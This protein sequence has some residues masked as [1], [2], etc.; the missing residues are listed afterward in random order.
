MTCSSTHARDT[1]QLSP[2]AGGCGCHGE[3]P[4]CSI[5]LHLQVERTAWYRKAGMQEGALLLSFCY[6]YG[7]WFF[8]HGCFWNGSKVVSFP[9]GVWI[10]PLLLAS[11]LGTEETPESTHC[12][13]PLSIPFLGAPQEDCCLNSVGQ[14]LQDS[15]HPC[16]SPPSSTHSFWSPKTKV[17]N[18]WTVEGFHGATTSVGKQLLETSWLTSVCTIA[19]VLHETYVC[20]LP[21]ELP[22]IQMQQVDL[23]AD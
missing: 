3:R 11:P 4:A 5:T 8:D 17:K 9:L 23:K 1:A 15:A 22:A 20:H 13:K 18:K 12:L 7:E 21:F 10:F 2:G 16:H 19:E 6:N 14:C